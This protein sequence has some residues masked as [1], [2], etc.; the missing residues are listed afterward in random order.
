MKYFKPKTIT[1]ENPDKLE[2][3]RLHIDYIIS[4]AINVKENFLNKNEDY[5]TIIPDDVEIINEDETVVFYNY[6][7][8]VVEV[9]TKIVNNSLIINLGYTKK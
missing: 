3:C 9:A 2:V 8:G 1:I 7:G 4:E 5:E 6:R